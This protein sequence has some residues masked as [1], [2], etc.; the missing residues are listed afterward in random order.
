MAPGK[1][2]AHG[3]LLLTLAY[4]GFVSLGFPDGIMGVAW[5][6]MRLD[7]GVGVDAVGWLLAAALVSYLVSSLGTGFLMARVGV[8]VLLAASTATTAAGL[9]VYGLAPSLGVGIGAALLV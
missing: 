6:S 8:G 7:F 1:R 2:L 9:A 5:P 4:L 3:T